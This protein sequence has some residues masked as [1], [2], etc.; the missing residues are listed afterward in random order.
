MRRLYPA[1]HY[2]NLVAEA[3]VAELLGKLG[4]K[5]T[6]GA[7]ITASIEKL[8][9]ADVGTQVDFIAWKEATIQNLTESLKDFG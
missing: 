2:S 1:A 3:S 9:A 8:K 5:D 6:A 7:V 4:D